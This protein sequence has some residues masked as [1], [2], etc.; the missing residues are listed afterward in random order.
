MATTFLLKY[1]ALIEPSPLPVIFTLPTSSTWHTVW[2]VEVNF[3]QRGH[4]FDVAVGEMGQHEQLLLGALFEHDVLRG[5]ISSR[6]I[7]GSS[8]RRGRLAGGDPFGQYAILVRIDREPQAA[9]VRNRAGRLG[10]NQAAARIAQGTIRRPRGLPRD[11][12][13]VGLR[14]RNRAGESLNPFFPAAAPWQAP[15]LQPAFVSTDWT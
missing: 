15:E 10:Q 9:L 5:A 2:L 13:E 3:A 1:Q 8:A 4:V 12:Q 11:R 14:D 7:R 6:S